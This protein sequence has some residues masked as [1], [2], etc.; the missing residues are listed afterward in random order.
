MAGGEGSRLYPAT[1]AISKQLIPVYDKPM[2]YYPISVV[3]KAQI[4]DILVVSTPR[5]IPFYEDLLS[6]GN[7]W[8]INIRYAIQDNPRGI[9]DAFRVGKE[10]LGDCNPV[11]I[12]GDNIFHGASMHELLIRASLRT[13]GSTVFAFPVNDPNRYGVIEFNESGEPTS[14]VEKPNNPKSNYAL[15]GL[16]FYDAEVMNYFKDLKPSKRGELEITD[17]NNKYLSQGAL[18]VEKMPSGFTWLDTGTHESLIQANQFVQTIQQRQ[19]IL[20]GSPEEEAF[21]NHWI[22]SEKLLS[23]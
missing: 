20:V 9:A 5:D 10:F 15:T 6:D 19:G 1:K 18:N 13:E 16:Y 14:I 22:S 17:I 23:Q 21:K 4:Q 2:I 11:L 8:G 3:I 12:L 7:Q